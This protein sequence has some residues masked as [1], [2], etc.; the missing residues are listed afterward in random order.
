MTTLYLYDRNGA[1][2]NYYNSEDDEFDFYE[3]MLLKIAFVDENTF[4]VT[5]V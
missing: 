2:L 3:R 1:K 4:Q 5:M